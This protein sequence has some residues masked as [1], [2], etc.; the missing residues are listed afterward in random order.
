MNQ[1]SAEDQAKAKASIEALLS[2]VK[3]R[4]ADPSYDGGSH[5]QELCSLGRTLGIK[6]DA[7]NTQFRV[8]HSIR[9]ACR[10]RQP[11]GGVD[12]EALEHGL[13]QVE[14]EREEER[15]KREHILGLL[16]NT[17]MEHG[18][19]KPRSRKAC[20]ACNSQD[21]LDKIVAGWKGF[22]MELS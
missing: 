6:I 3:G 4:A 19:C 17:K 2:I 16:R 10:R 14:E 9:D 13:V 18:I 8:H 7:G 12:A 15:R 1:I 20:T 21:E 11:L 22:T 5:A